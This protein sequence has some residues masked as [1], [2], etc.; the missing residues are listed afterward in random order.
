MGRGAYPRHFGQAKQSLSML[1]GVPAGVGRKPA[2]V[3]PVKPWP[4]S[5]PAGWVSDRGGNGRVPRFCLLA[6]ANRRP[7][8]MSPAAVARRVCGHGP[9][10]ATT[11]TLPAAA[12][13]Q[14]GFRRL[15]PLVALIGDLRAWTPAERRDLVALMRAK[16]RKRER[17]Y[18]LRLRK[19]DRLRKALADYCQSRR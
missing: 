2:P 10:G 9:A 14:A 4:G 11:P 12:C 8:A 16:N 1:A 17:E 18:V 7:T 5:F 19:S 6:V 13:A 15:A 3:E